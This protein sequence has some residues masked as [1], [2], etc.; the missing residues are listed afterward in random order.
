[1]YW[2]RVNENGRKIPLG[3]SELHVQ[4]KTDFYWLRAISTRADGKPVDLKFG[5]RHCGWVSRWFSLFLLLKWKSLFVL[6]F[7]TPSA[8]ELIF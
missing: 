1:M 4:M 7:V 3:C 8:K 2:V 5:H 6:I